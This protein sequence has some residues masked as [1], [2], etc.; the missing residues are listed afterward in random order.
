MTG[1][2]WARQYTEESNHEQFQALWKPLHKYANE[3]HEIIEQ[4]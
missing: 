1:E 3:N 4:T 2:L